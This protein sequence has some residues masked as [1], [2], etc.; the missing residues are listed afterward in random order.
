M[1]TEIQT[2]HMGVSSFG[3]AEST[4]AVLPSRPGLC[5][6]AWLKERIDGGLTSAGL[7]DVEIC[8]FWAQM[9]DTYW[10]AYRQRSRSD[11]ISQ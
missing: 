5:L 1:A 2:F 9:P 4:S 11:M 10:A 6:T 3:C 7:V 8:F